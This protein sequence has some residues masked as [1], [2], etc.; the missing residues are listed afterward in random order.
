M[1]GTL[2]D[3]FAR[4]CAREPA[5]RT[6]SSQQARELIRRW[7]EHLRAEIVR[8]SDVAAT[9]DLGAPPAA[10]RTAR[11]EQLTRAV[12]ALQR[13]LTASLVAMRMPPAALPRQPPEPGPE[14]QGPD[15]VSRALGG[16]KRMVAPGREPAYEPGSP[17]YP[18]PDPV[19]IIQRDALADQ[20]RAACDALDDLLDAAEPPAPVVTA[21]PWAE[22]REL[23][24]LFHDLL[25]ARQTGHAAKALNR[26]D[27]LADQLAQRHGIEVIEHSAQAEAVGW[28][29]MSTTSDTSLDRI[30]TVRP[31]LVARGRLIAVGEAVRPQGTAG[32]VAVTPHG[33]LARD[34]L[35]RPDARA[36]SA[37]TLDEPTV[38][39]DVRQAERTTGARQTDQHLSQ[40]GRTEPGGTAWPRR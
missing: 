5:S 10:V 4:A 6:L 14:H 27:H 36:V 1:S 21:R 23:V 38:L 25:S 24:G 7:A 13:A 39:A 34:L 35:S 22:D 11:A 30:R 9:G 28:F 8:A 20:V 31:A 33:P 16:L 18:P 26:L 2:A 15:P 32:D 17:A 37:E 3:L 19:M 12:D 29:S 40:E